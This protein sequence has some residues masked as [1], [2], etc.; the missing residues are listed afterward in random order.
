MR[1][2]SI[3][4]WESNILSKCST[5]EAT[6]ICPSTIRRSDKMVRHGTTTRGR[7]CIFECHPR[8]RRISSITIIVRTAQPFRITRIS[9]IRIGRSVTYE[10]KSCRGNIGWKALNSISC[11]PDTAHLIRNMFWRDN[12]SRKAD[13]WCSKS[14][15]LIVV[16][17]TETSSIGSCTICW[18]SYTLFEMT[19]WCCLYPSAEHTAEKNTDRE[20]FSHKRR[21]NTSIVWNRTIL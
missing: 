9:Q 1:H 17:I 16:A 19:S 6:N 14:N 20:I 12:H 13:K 7:C 10:P 5:T 15:I 3:R 2:S 4:C 11:S 8:S 21:L 18:A